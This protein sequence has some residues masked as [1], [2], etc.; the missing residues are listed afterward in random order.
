[1]LFRS[2]IERMAAQLVT[3][4]SAELALDYQR[5]HGSFKTVAGELARLPLDVEQLG[6]V[7]RTIA[8]EQALFEMLTTPGAKLDA[9]AV[10]AHAAELVDSGFE[11]LAISYVAADRE[12]EGLRAHAQS[13]QWQLAVL[14]LVCTG[15]AVA[16][17]LVLSRV[18]ARPVGELDA[19]IRR[20]GG[21]DFESPI[22]VSGPQDLRDLGTRLDWLRRR[23]AELEEQK[24]RFQIGRAHV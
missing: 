8:H 13:I 7:Y 5:V 19:A 18:I 11:V 16:V 23:L 21:A 1:M 14:L 4:P 6:V 24:D 20:L 10:H 9:R 12:A 15:L 3:E 17:A 2:S 22:D